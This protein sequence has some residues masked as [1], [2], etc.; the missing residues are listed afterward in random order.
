MYPLTVSSD[1]LAFLV[2]GQPFVWR[3][4]LTWSLYGRALYFGIENARE[5]VRDRRS[6]GANT[7]CCSLMLSWGFPFTPQEGHS[8]YD[9]DYWP[10][11]TPFVRMCA[12]EQMRV[13]FIVFADTKFLM[14]DRN[15]QKAHWQRLYTHLAAEPNVTFVLVNQPG[16]HT[17]AI[18]IG[19]IA[20]FEPPPPI[21]GFP[22]L[23]AAPYNP[24]EDE[25][26]LA[27]PGWAFSCFCSKRNDPN[28]WAE[29]GGYSMATVVSIGAG[30]RPPTH[31]ATV[32]FEPVP[33]GRRP[34]WSDPDKARQFA[35]SQAFK[36]TVGGNVYSDLDARSE[37]YPAGVVRDCAVEYLG[38]LPQ[39]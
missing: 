34:E 16:H 18:S 26:P 10:F 19:G 3:G 9:A 28:W 33:Y 39:P 27:F 23:L 2:N 32:L 14:P 6:V 25:L 30:D 35:R 12:A 7:V 29:A 20:E 38:N 5:V 36:G 21:A 37:V 31:Q 24:H 13:C 1:R 4:T 15:A 22:A 8:L 17:Q 11:L